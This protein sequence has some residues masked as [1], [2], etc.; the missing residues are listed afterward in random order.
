MGVL[1]CSFWNWFFIEL[2]INFNGGNVD[3]GMFSHC[4]VSNRIEIMADQTDGME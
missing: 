4:Y 3:R 2:E 1:V